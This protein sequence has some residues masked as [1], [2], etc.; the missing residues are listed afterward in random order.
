M[1]KNERTGCYIDIEANGLG[2]HL[3]SLFIGYN[4]AKENNS[5]FAYKSLPTIHHNKIGKDYNQKV[6]DLFGLG[7]FQKCNNDMIKIPYDK[8][9]NTQHLKDCEVFKKAFNTKSQYPVRDIDWIIHIRR[10]DIS[11]SQNT[12]R[13]VNYDYYNKFIIRI[14]T[15]YKGIIHIYTDGNET[16]IR[17]NLLDTNLSIN[18]SFDTLQVFCDMVYC[19]NLVVG[20]SSFSFSAGILNS[21]NVYKDIVLSKDHSYYHKIPEHWKYVNEGVCPNNCNKLY[22]DVGLSS[23]AIQSQSWLEHDKDIFVVGFEPSPEARKKIII[24][25]TDIDDRWLRTEN[26]CRIKIEPTA[27]SSSVGTATFY[28]PGIDV[29]CSSLYK[30]KDNSCGIQPQFNGVKESFEVQTT[31]LKDY[32]NENDWLLKRFSRIEYIKLDAQGADLEIIRSS[33]EFIKENV[34]WLTAEGDGGYYQQDH[35]SATDFCSG[36]N[37]IKTMTQAGFIQVNHSNTSDPTF[38]NPKFIDYKDVF[39]N[40]Y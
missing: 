4:W 19:K 26:H 17:K 8:I 2:C 1:I 13:Y 28:R 36:E 16:E 40:Q 14:R 10:N 11:Q 31:T 34:V 24:E 27:L 21:N 29:G 33:I 37:I 3:V 15:F 30:P 39:I 38:Y 12:D 35:L 32:F 18:V 7:T 6:N 20:W 22:V 9:Y 5:Q 23:E 25:R